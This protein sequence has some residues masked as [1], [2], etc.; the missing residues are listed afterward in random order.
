MEEVEG[1]LY[2][3]GSHVQSEE[4]DAVLAGAAGVAVDALLLELE[5]P[6]PEPEPELVESEP[7]LLE[8]DDELESLDEAVLDDDFDFPPRLSVL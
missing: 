1:R 8:S 6:E 2:R 4:G 3:P 7:D 5:S